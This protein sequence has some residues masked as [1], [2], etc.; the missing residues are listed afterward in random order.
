MREQFK[1]DKFYYTLSESVKFINKEL[2]NNS[3]IESSK[4]QVSSK[5]IVHYAV[6]DRCKLIIAIPP[7]VEVRVI[8][9][10]FNG[11]EVVTVVTPNEFVPTFFPDFLELTPADCQNIELFG[12]CITQEFERGYWIDS[13]LL[14]ELRIAFPKRSSPA[15]KSYKDYY[16]WQF[17]QNDQPISLEIQH[18]NLLVSASEIRRLLIWLLNL[19]TDE[20]KSQKAK[21]LFLLEDN[22]YLFSEAFRSL[23]NLALMGDSE[24]R[25]FKG[26]KGDIQIARDDVIDYLQENFPIKDRR[27]DELVSLLSPKDQNKNL[28]KDSRAIV[29]YMRFNEDLIEVKKILR[30]EWQFHIEKLISVMEMYEIDFDKTKLH[31]NNE[32]SNQYWNLLHKEGALN[33]RINKLPTYQKVIK[34]ITQR[35]KIPETQAKI[36]AQLGRVILPKNNKKQNLY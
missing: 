34:K 2:K 8:H 36:L 31:K 5:D 12:K 24:I 1:F 26:Y 30:E 20:N 19:E 28:D 10:E 3:H 21:E 32:I 13:L 16:A 9:K 33:L 15:I 22:E 29:P 4:Q 6:V 14:G 11:D 7:D 25:A 18:K 27:V 35:T 17:V 23:W